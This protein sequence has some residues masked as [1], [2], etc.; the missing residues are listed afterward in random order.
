MVKDDFLAQAAILLL[1]LKIVHGPATSVLRQI[2]EELVIVYRRRC[3]FHDDLG[4][5]AVELEDDV[6]VL[7]LK[8]QLL[9]PFQTF[10]VYG[11]AGRLVRKSNYIG[12]Y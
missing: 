12:I 1:E 3:F 2:D 9:I 6:L 8:F 11:Y 10:W 5:L 4:P 7:L